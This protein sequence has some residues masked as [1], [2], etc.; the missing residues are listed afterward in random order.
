M[1]AP[2]AH[3]FAVSRLAKS[4]YYCDTDTS[5]WGS[6]S[7][8]NLIWYDSEAALLGAWNALHPTSP[9]TLHAPCR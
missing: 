2:R 1:P 4:H 7:P 6:I 3:R 9:I 5:G 8:V